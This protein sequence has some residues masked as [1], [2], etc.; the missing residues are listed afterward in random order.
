[1]TDLHTP[2]IEEAHAL[3]VKASLAFMKNFGDI[4]KPLS[5]AASRSMSYGPNKYT[6]II[7]ATMEKAGL[8][9]EY[10]DNLGQH[11]VY[12]AWRDAVQFG[13]GGNVN[14][15]E[16]MGEVNPKA[17]FLNNERMMRLF[18]DSADQPADDPYGFPYKKKELVLYNEVLLKMFQDGNH[19]G[20]AKKMAAFQKNTA[21]V[22]K[23]FDEF[24]A[25]VKPELD[26]PTI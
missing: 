16:Q 1:M 15:N 23:A 21:A 22:E 10:G 26:I 7:S 25:V 17:H 3:L 19:K 2:E 4:A 6:P 18:V 24:L 5:K 20:L 14:S 8:P 9:K 13:I 11:V 12:Q